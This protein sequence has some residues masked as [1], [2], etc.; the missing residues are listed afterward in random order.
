MA[1]AQ[2]P[3]LVMAASAVVFVLALAT[4]LT[5]LG[6]EHLGGYAP[7]QLCLQERY[8]YYFAVPAALLALILSR[9]DL[10]GAARVL[11][12]LVALAFMCNAALGVYHAGAEWKWWPGPETCGGGF[13]LKWGKDGIVDTPVIRCDEASWWFLGLSFAAWNAVVSAVL[14]AIAAFGAARTR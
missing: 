14:A 5:A 1:Q 9:M 6:F 12:V 11:L 7:C 2:A 13:D 10:N 3:R 4:I 8:A